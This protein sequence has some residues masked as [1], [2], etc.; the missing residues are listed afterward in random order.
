MVHCDSTIDLLIPVLRTEKTLPSPEFVKTILKAFI[1][2]IALEKRSD[3]NFSNPNS[4]ESFLKVYE[5]TENF[6]SNVAKISE[7]LSVSSA[8]ISSPRQFFSVDPERT[9]AATNFRPNI[10]CFNCGDEGHTWYRCIISCNL[11]NCPR[12]CDLETHGKSSTLPHLA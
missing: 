12:I 8:T 1:N 11:K 3:A 9:A 10:M 2:G 7:K 4:I 6:I 5:A